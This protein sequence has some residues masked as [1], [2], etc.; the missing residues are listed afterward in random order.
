MKNDNDLNEVH[1]QLLLDIARRT[2]IRFTTLH[3][4]PDFSIDKPELNKQ[5][6]VFVTLKKGGELRGCI[7]QLASSDP[8]WK[9]VREQTIASAS[10]DNRFPKVTI[11]ELSQI[12]IELSI[13]SPLKK[14]NTIEE[15]QLGKH[16]VLITKGLQSGVFLPQVAEE[17][18][19]DR[20]TF[21]SNLC[22][23]KAGLPPDCYKDPETEIYLFTV[24]KF[25]ELDMN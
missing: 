11:S 4:V 3:I 21:L 14:T 23:Q 7:G 2:L 17:T 24:Q 5:Y 18:G 6:G 1:G 12:T 20:D 19:W 15:I 25:E 9:T 16:G 10:E 13:L 8:V 22:Y